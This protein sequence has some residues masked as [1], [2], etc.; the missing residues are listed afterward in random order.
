MKLIALRI[1]IISEFVPISAVKHRRQGRLTPCGGFLGCPQAPNNSGPPQAMGVQLS[2]P[3]LSHPAANVSPPG[4][5]VTSPPLCHPDCLLTTAWGGLYG[6][7]F[8]CSISYC[9]FLRRCR[10]AS[11]TIPVSVFF[12]H[13]YSRLSPVLCR[14]RR[15]RG[16]MTVPFACAGIPVPLPNEP[17]KG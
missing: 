13:R 6:S 12:Y 3:T 4:A 9:V 14:A 1:R 17:E 7:L 5:A 11:G 8:S 16:W 15:Q 10:S 2:P